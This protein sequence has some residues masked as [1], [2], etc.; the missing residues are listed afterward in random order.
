M[1]FCRLAAA[2]VVFLQEKKRDEGETVGVGVQEE[3]DAIFDTFAAEVCLC[4]CTRVVCVCV[5]VCDGTGTT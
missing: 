5:C 4:V 2:G 3:I 1:Q